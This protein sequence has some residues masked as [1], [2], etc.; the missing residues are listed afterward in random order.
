[1]NVSYVTFLFSTEYGQL[2]NDST[3]DILYAHDTP[4]D[5]GDFYVESADVGETHVCA[6]SSNA[7]VKCWGE[8]R[9]GRLGYGNSNNVGSGTGSSYSM[10]NCVEVDLGSNFPVSMVSLGYDHSCALSVAL[11]EIR[12]WGSGGSGKLGTGNTNNIGDAEG[13]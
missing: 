2:G 6:V 10:T 9:H 12:C 8:G 4:I 11:H 1:M 13:M 3:D 5:L 7:T